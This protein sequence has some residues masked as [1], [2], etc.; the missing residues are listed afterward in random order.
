MADLTE[1]TAPS[2]RMPSTIDDAG[3]DPVWLLAHLITHERDYRMCLFNDGQ[4]S[5]PTRHDATP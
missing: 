4:F 3:S 1:S 2:L 5:A